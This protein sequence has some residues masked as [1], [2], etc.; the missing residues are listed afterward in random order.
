[1][2]PEVLESFIRSFIAASPWPE[3][4][5]VWHGGEPTL[6]GL[7]FYRRVVEYQR[8]HLPPGRT[9]RNNLQ[10]NGTLLDDAWCLFLRE[11]GFLVGISLDGPAALHDAFRTDAGGRPSHERVLRGLRLL[12]RHHVDHN[13]LCTVNSANAGHPLEVYRYLRDLG[14]DWIQFIPIVEH[15]GGGA[16]SD[17]SVRPEDYGAFLNAVFDDWVHRDVGRV[18]VQL[19]EEC[20][21]VWAGLPASLC[22]LRE[23]C[24]QALVM[25]HGGDVFSCDHFVVPEHRLANL[26]DTPLQQMAASPAQ[27]AFGADKRRLLPPEC[28]SCRWRFICNGGCPKDR[29]VRDAAGHAGLNY[30]C[31]GFSAFF[32]HADPH[33]RRL[34]ELWRRGQAPALLMA[35]LRA[36]SRADRRSPGRN[37]PCPC[38]SGRKYK[39]CC[40]GRDRAD[41]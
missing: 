8:R 6:A 31:A 9:A 5:F 22:V 25:E 36:E 26:R 11:H 37:D 39:R 23:T 33:L 10:T 19:F 29:F 4:A 27:A 17:R 16:V 1:M 34:A 20:A 2:S 32:E 21:S 28:V 38:G 35:E 7:A 18:F 12:Q 40:L 13:V 30:L 41:A 24:G 15:V 3:V 14:V